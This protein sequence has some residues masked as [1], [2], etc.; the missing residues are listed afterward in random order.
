M[1]DADLFPIR[2]DQGCS[3]CPKTLS[4][5]NNNLKGI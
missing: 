4:V 5:R 2:F 3:L 1:T